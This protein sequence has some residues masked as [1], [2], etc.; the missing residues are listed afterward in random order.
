MLKKN[1]NNRYNKTIRINKHPNNNLTN[2]LIDN[3]KIKVYIQMLIT[4]PT[5][6]LIITLMIHGLENQWN[7]AKKNQIP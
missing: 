5:T 7:K 1:N 6:K 3:S 4:H 2:N